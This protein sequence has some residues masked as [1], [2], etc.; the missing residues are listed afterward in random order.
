MSLRPF[1]IEQL[2]AF[3]DEALRALSPE[4]FW[5]AISAKG[6]WEKVTG[7]KRLANE[8]RRRQMYGGDLG[9]KRVRS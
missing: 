3:T 7:D 8:A 5:R 9:D 6:A 4:E 1:T 2:S